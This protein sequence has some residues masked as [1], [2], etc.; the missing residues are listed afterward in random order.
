VDG[1]SG[2]YDWMTGC[3]AGTEDD[4]VAGDPK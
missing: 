4:D 3:G 1:I 2:R